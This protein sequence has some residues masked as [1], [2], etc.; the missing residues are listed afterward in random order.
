MQ[1]FRRAILR[2]STLAAASIA[3]FA[4]VTSAGIADEGETAFK[5]R[6]GQCHG[7]RDI[8]FWGRQRPDA[9]ARRAWL[10][11][12][13]RGHYPPPDAEKDLIIAYI[14]K[15]IGSAPPR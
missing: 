15:I 3:G 5:T 9:M 1:Y 13:L 2:L 10:E 4:L 7:S 8:Q 6:C 11:R 12:F 14:E